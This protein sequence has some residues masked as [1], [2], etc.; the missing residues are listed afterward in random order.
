MKTGA[1]IVAWARP[2]AL[3]N[4]AYV[5]GAMTPIG[6]P[7]PK[8]FD[9]S[10]FAACAAYQG[11]GVIFGCD[12]DSG[13]PHHIYGGTIYFERDV[14][15]FKDCKVS[16]EQAMAI[17]GALVL[18]FVHGESNHHIV[19]SDGKGGT[20][21]AA[22]TREGVIF[23]T[24]HGRRWTTG[25]CPPGINFGPLPAPSAVQAPAYLYR[26]MSP[27]MDDPKIMVIQRSL[28]ILADGIYGPLTAAAVREFQKNHGGLVVDGEVGPITAKALGVSFP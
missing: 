11:G 22:C 27:L 14:E 5:L 26:Y 15:K 10:K 24:L 9:C 28:G 6:E 3:R 21:E 13:D 12:N 25:I 18:R 23:N 20:I 19:I 7:D 16:V 17:P 8:V 2:H 1:D 4:D